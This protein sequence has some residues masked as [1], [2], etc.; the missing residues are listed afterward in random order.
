MSYGRNGGISY[1][2]MHFSYMGDI[3]ASGLVDAM[4]WYATSLVVNQAKLNVPQILGT[5]LASGLYH[6]LGIYALGQGVDWVAVIFFA[7]QVGVL[8]VEKLWK[9]YTGT[10]VGGWPGRVSWG[11]L[12]SI[13]ESSADRWNGTGL[14]L[15]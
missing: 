3:R 14:G 8:M 15:L 6:G 5:F 9:R 12:L 11:P 2:D 7:G 4:E 13:S 1:Y 10:Q